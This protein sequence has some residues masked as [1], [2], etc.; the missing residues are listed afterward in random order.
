MICSNDNRGL[1]GRRRI[2][3]AVLLL[4]GSV[5]LGAVV[6]APVVPNDEALIL[7]RL[8]PRDGEVWDEIRALHAALAQNPADASVA[9]DLARRYLALN[10]RVG[11]PRL[12]AYASRALAHWDGA[13]APPVEVGLERALIAQTEHRFDAAREGLVAVLERSPR[14]A[15]AWLALAALDTVQGRYADAKRSCGRLLLL[16]DAAVVGAC[17]AAVQAMTGDAAAAYR[18]LTENLARPE[19]LDPESAAWL[20]T[21]AA[22]IAERLDLHEDAARHYRT[23]LAA[24]ASQPGIYLLT[25]YADFL[26]RRGRPAAVIELLESAPA[27]DPLLL[28]LALAEARTDRRAP[29]R[30][31]TLRY[32][33]E[34]AL[35][36]D[37]RAHARE[38]AFFALYLDDDA[39]RGLSL[40][41]DNWTLQREP[42]DARLVLEAA[43]AAETPSAAQPVRDWLAS[44]GVE[45]GELLSSS[46]RLGGP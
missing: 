33:L 1:G 43:A 10:R 5:A 29:A 31:E 6:A 11:D 46:N 19:S 45:L 3:A 20:A 17:F 4:L 13:A 36:G 18:F 14:S 8:P 39:T 32:R 42:I 7:E 40:A 25:A 9:A 37:D 2:R 15:Q 28:R 30:L 38:A 41:L 34:L 16:Q 22:E 23:A 12:V 26:L 24:S 21:L 44:Q 27:A 35:R